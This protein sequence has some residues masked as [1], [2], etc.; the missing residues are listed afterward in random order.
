MSELKPRTIR[1]DEETIAKFKEISDNI[2]GNQ[3][4][5]FEKLIESYE[6]QQGKMILTEKAA[7]IEQFEKYVSCLIHMYMRTLEDNQ[8]VTATV[9]IEFSKQLKM[10]DDII[11]DLQEKIKKLEQE[12]Q[13]NANMNHKLLSIENASQKNEE[14]A[15]TLQNALQDKSKR[16]EELEASLTKHE[17]EKDN[18]L[19]QE[20]QIRQLEEELNQ[21]KTNNSL[22]EKEKITLSVEQDKKILTFD[23]EH[24][25]EITKLQTEHQ[26][27]I[28]TYQKKYMELLEVIKQERTSSEV[29]KKK[30]S[31]QLP[32]A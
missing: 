21:L 17:K 12:R 14:L 32:I 30:T 11:L 4:L 6:L 20:K 5:A 31:G 13:S 19:S 16:I 29:V 26:K 10:K 22:L 18:L 3:Q 25:K 9:R 2:G 28:D 23:R 8:N 15:K 24:Q 1:T 7:D 27:E